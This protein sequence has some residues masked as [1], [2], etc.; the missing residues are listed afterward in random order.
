MERI[1]ILTRKVHLAAEQL[2]RMKKEKDK[3]ESELKY[4]QEENKRVQ[5]LSRE[6]EQFRER[7]AAIANRIEKLLKK[8]KHE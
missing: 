8:M 3:L 7:H 5:V 2:T 1:E 6:N 4:L